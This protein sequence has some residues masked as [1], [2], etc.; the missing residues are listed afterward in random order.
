MMTEK[1]SCCTVIFNGISLT[2]VACRTTYVKLLWL[3]LSHFF[4][5]GIS[6]IKILW[7]SSGHEDSINSSFS[8]FI[9][10]RACI[11]GNL[12]VY[13]N[14][15]KTPLIKVNC[16]K[17]SSF[18]TLS[19]K[20]RYSINFSPLLMASR[21]CRDLYIAKK[22]KLYQNQRSKWRNFDK[23]KYWHLVS[24]TDMT[25]PCMISFISYNF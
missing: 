11:L 12:M 21:P 4:R 8:V 18:P 9:D 7:Y 6:F 10:F 3:E 14:I 25:L 2:Q 13:G 19:G 23:A 15:W 24:I 5:W 16:G 22:Q 1:Y 20:P 17:P